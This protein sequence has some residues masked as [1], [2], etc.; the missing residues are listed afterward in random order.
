MEP[1]FVTILPLCEVAALLKDPGMITMYLSRMGYDCTFVSLLPTQIVDERDEL[2]QIR[3]S[4]KVVGLQE[5]MTEKSK[6]D[7]NNRSIL[8]YIW[9]EAKHIDVLNLYYLKHSLFY[10]T[11]YKLLNP[12]GVLYIK[13][14]INYLDFILQEKDKIEPLRRWVYSLYLH[15]VPD[16]VSA[17]TNASMGYVRNKFKPQED[18]L[19]LIPNGIDDQLIENN[20]ISI[21]PFA[22]R[23]NR[24]VVVGRIGAPEKQHE[25]ILEAIA[26]I[27][28]WK[29]WEIEFVGAIKSDFNTKIKNFYQKYAHLKQRVHF[30]GPIYDRKILLS[31]Y[32]ESK[33]F[34][35]SSQYESFG[36]AYV[37]AQYFGN[38][39]L[40][41]RVSSIDDFVED[42]ND[43]GL[44]INNAEEM[45]CAMQ[46]IID[47]VNQID[48][49][50]EK[51]VRHGEHFRWSTI[52]KHLD[53][54]IRRVI[55]AK[56]I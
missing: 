44:V 41:T 23:K 40:S 38:Y 29:D 45:G 49:S 39:I 11:L 46:D 56:N 25:L 36:L 51:R 4:I 5:K 15:N 34:I 24:F 20:K 13:L 55:N 43:L 50:F 2:T 9:Q 14:D 30:I 54:E 6:I 3:E 22:K 27:A 35:M 52:C 28:E 37:E 21:S 16:L 47:G 53:D 19:L 42:D 10:G 1:T 32:N 48:I 18:K 31:K 8:R 12:R 26:N 7:M 17:E 33:V